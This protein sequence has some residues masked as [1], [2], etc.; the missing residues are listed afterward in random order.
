M[1]RPEDEFHDFVV[2]FADPLARLAF[3][4]TVGAPGMA[5]DSGETMTIKAFVQVRR[6]WRDA[7]A[8][9][10]PEPLAVEA[11]VAQLP[12][13]HHATD[14]GAHSEGTGHGEG[15]ANPG[16]SQPP[17]EEWTSARAM[18]AET[19][20]PAAAFRRPART[21]AAVD[22]APAVDV[23]G[24]RDALWT[25]WQTL[26][27]R[28]RVPLVFADVDAVSRRLTGLD[29]PESF[30]SWRRRHTLTVGAVEQ[31]RR[32]LEGRAD[33]GADA[34]ALSESDFMG[35]LGDTLREHASTAAVPI[36]SYSVV[37]SHVQ[38]ARR[39]V[40]TATAAMV[41]VLAAGSVA[42]VN[43]STSRHPSTVSAA[44]ASLRAAAQAAALR[45]QAG[46]LVVD[47]PVRGNVSKDAALLRSVRSTFIEGHPDAT[48]RVQV[49]LAADT[50]AFRVAY[51]T[52]NSHNGVL[53]SWMY[54]AVGSADLI[55]G[56][57]SYGGPLTP[58]SVLTA[59]L[60]IPSGR[61]EIIVIAPPETTSM[62]V[63]DYGKADSAFRTLD[64]RDGIAIAD[65]SNVY[66]PGLVLAIHVRSLEI[67]RDQVPMID[68]TRP[69]HYT[70]YYTD[71]PTSGASTGPAP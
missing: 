56:A 69:A 62:Q 38:H 12:H 25:A 71:P 10:A 37:R 42:A 14:A 44:V 61:T 50:A 45:D 19:T 51:V 70:E 58:T 24:L 22:V 47:W 65:A 7:E 63:G 55:E 48:G 33:L 32:E 41:A 43:L 16:D 35:L 15:I 52:A 30:G 40:A 6:N 36:D 59:A 13:R 49:L 27:P 4:L 54:G 29:V 66:V 68:L 39:R 57:F 17:V 1:T 21:T 64:Y 26:D 53:Q 31:L 2:G 23:Q 46:P 18:G 67:F 3:V 28:P 5:D 8:T 9:G 60:S 34:A 20:D 11:L